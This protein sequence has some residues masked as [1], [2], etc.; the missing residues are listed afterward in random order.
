MKA[1]FIGLGIVLLTSTTL[2]AQM[3]PEWMVDLSVGSGHHT[4][5][6]A[7]VW[8]FDQ[9]SGIVSIAGRYRLGPPARTAGYLKLSVSPGLPMGHDAICSIAPNGSCFQYLDDNSGLGASIGIQHA[10]AARLIAGAG[11]GSGY[12]A[13]HTR[14]F[15]EGDAAIGLTTHFSVTVGVSYMR[16]KAGGYPYWI[17]PVSVG[18]RFR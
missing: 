1:A 7:E 9:A 12:Y 2:S 15:M 16:W 4:S 10:F 6:A 11:I 8:Y 17:A 14:A 18:L 13:G 5:R 3:V